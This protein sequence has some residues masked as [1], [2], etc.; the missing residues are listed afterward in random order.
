MMKGGEHLRIW[1]ERKMTAV[2]VVGGSVAD[3]VA[4][5]GVAGLDPHFGE[6]RTFE[7]SRFSDSKRIAQFH[8]SLAPT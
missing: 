7:R 6:R 2:L 8:L 1:R 3:G 4:G 5:L